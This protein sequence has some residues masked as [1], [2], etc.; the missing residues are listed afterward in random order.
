MPK[1]DLM[2]RSW[3]MPLVLAIFGACVATESPR[4]TEQTQSA[5]FEPAEGGDCESALG[6]CY[7]A[8]DQSSTPSHCLKVCEFDYFLCT[9]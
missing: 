7:S 4:A 1:E 9:E 3:C 8:C 5:V 6:A 2:L